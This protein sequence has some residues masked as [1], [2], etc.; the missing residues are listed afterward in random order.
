MRGRS[1]LRQ[2]RWKFEHAVERRFRERIMNRF[3]GDPGAQLFIL[4]LP[5]SGTTLVYQYIVH[6]YHVAY[7]TN[8]VASHPYNPCQTTSRQ[9]KQYPPY[10][11]DFRSHY[12]HSEGTMA[13]NEAGSYWWRFFGEGRYTALSD[14]SADDIHDIQK[15]VA[16]IQAVFDGALFVNKDV[17]HILRIDALARMFPRSHLLVIERNAT[18]VALSILRGRK[19]LTGNYTSWTSAKPPEYD[20]LKDLPA[21]QQICGQVVGLSG[22]LQHDLDHVDPSRVHRIAYEQ[23]CQCPE[24][25]MESVAEIFSGVGTKNPLVTEF[26]ARSREPQGPIEKELADLVSNARVL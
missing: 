22:R 16:T 18:D 17:K 15:T 5:R 25:A 12:G 8:G 11:S 9:H 7:F 13:P 21:A 10:R 20:H 3:D 4:G 1:R 19:D 23:F 2:L 26:P 24:R 14:M 6:R